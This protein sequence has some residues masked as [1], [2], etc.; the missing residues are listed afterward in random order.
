MEDFHVNKPIHIYFFSQGTP[1]DYPEF[2]QFPNLHW[3]MDGGTRILFTHG[4]C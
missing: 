4:L 3:C 2:E 1:E